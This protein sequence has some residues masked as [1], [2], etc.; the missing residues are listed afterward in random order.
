MTKYY[1]PD[2]INSL[3]LFLTNIISTIIKNF[4]A[5]GALFASISTVET[6]LNLIGAVSSNALYIATVRVLRGFIFL[7]YAGLNVIC[8]VLMM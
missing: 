3:I 4:S 1:Y 8:T 5:T 7:L 6:L 2:I